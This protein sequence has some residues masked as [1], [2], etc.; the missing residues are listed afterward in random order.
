M[1]IDR[2]PFRDYTA[3]SALFVRRALVAFTGILLLSGVL[4]FNLYN[5]QIVRFQDYQTRSN[6]NRIKLVPIAPSRGII[7]DRNGTP[8]ALNRTIYQ[9]ELVPEKVDN[10]AAIL[11]GLKPIVDLTPEDIENFQK[12][13]KRSRRFTSIPVKTALTEVQVARFAVNQFNFP[14]VEVKG[15]QRRYYPYGSAL[16]HVIG[17]VSKINDRDVERLDKDGILA[18]YAATHDIGKLGIER[19]YEDT[20]H[21][22]TGYEEVEVNNRGRVIRQL[23]EEPPQAGKDIYLTID[24]ALQ[25]Y[26]E[27]LLTGSRSAVVVSDPRDGSIRA[28]VSNPSYDPNLFVDGISSKDYSGLLNDPN[29]PLINRATQGVY[30]PA[31]TVKPYIAVSALTAGVITKATSL[32]D[33]GWWQLPGSDKRYRDWKHWGHGRLNVTKS[34]EESADTFFYQVA[35]DMGID[36]LSEWMGKFGYGQYSGIDLSEE[37]NGNMPSRDWKFK[38]FKK[39]WYQGDT[40]PVGIGQGY[41]TATPIQIMKAMTTL[42]ND[43]TVKTPHLLLSTKIDGK[44]VPYQQQ[45]TTQIGDV[46]SGYWEIAKDGMYGVANRPNGTA[47]KSFADAP[48][49][50]AA[51]S[52]TAQVYGLKA[53]EIYNANKIS[54]HLRDHK[55]MTAFAPFNDPTVA[56]AVILENGGAGPAVGTIT[57]QILDHILLGDNTTQLPAEAPAPPGIEGD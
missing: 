30:P 14:G 42:I 33:P 57:R 7:Y 35:Y 45:E 52:G 54:E 21:G 10:L 47:R 4:A 38:R 29:K 5:L 31:S 26:I 55:L 27:E 51:K 43:G 46:H 44:L 9:L 37:R 19:Y 16:T 3:E 20:L 39:P 15:Y 49:K 1:K 36:R 41:W 2:N 25:T 40:I 48:Y 24:L 6:D 50:A 13:R 56:V 53:N 18:N 12:E 11:E 23:H 32:F 17:Y 34:L 8:L 22:K 28:L